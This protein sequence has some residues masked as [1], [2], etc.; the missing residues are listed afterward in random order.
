MTNY[1]IIAEFT[2]ERVFDFE[3]ISKAT[4][5]FNALKEELKSNPGY[6]IEFSQ[7]VYPAHRI[8]KLANEDGVI[9]SYEY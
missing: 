5:K 4:K 8:E 9:V 3:D 1:T 6:S 7:L 2:P